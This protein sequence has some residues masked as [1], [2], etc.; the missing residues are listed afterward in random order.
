MAPFA[1]AL[2]LLTVKRLFSTWSALRRS[3]S[4]ITVR[5]ERQAAMACAFRTFGAR[6]MWPSS[7]RVSL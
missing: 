2:F 1:K 4:A 7:T 5:A 3:S 6:R